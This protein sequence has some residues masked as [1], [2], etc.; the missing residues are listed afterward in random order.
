MLAVLVLICGEAE[1]VSPR[2]GGRMPEGFL[3]IVEESKA[4]YTTSR[5]WVSSR[6]SLPGGRPLRS[7]VFFPGGPDPVRLLPA[8]KGKIAIPVIAGLYSDFEGIPESADALQRRLFDGAAFPGTFSEYYDEVSFGL[9]DVTGTVYEWVG[10]SQSELYYTGYPTQGLTPGV[11]HTDEMI[12]ETVALLD[13]GVD[14]GLYD[15]DGPDGIPNSGDDD[16]YVDLLVIVHPTKGGECGGYDHMWSHSWQ[17]SGWNEE[18]QPLVTG[19]LSASGG[20]IL[21]DDYF[22][23]PT[24]SC[25]GGLI[26]IGVFCH[27]F[28]HSLGL[29]DLYD[30][31]GGGSGIGFWG[32]MGSGN[33]NTPQS[34]A[35]LSAWS[36]E[37]LGW[38][39]PVEI[40]WR[41]EERALES[42]GKSAEAFK[43]VLPAKRFRRMPNIFPVTGYAL[44]CGYTGAEADARGWNGGAG[45]G[46]GW[47][48]S[49][50]RHFHTDGIGDLT[51]EYNIGVDLEP[52]YDFAYL[53]L[54]TE[55]AEILLAE[56]SGTVDPVRETIV[57]SAFL[58]EGPSDFILK[59]LLTSDYNFSDEDN[60]YDSVEGWSLN[61]D[62][63]VLYGG[64]N[65][66]ASDFEEDAGGWLCDSEPSEY[67]LVENRRN[68]G[69]DRH[70]PGE[71]LLVW[72][73]ENSIAYSKLGNSGGYS[74]TQARGL[75][76]QEADGEFD[77]ISLLY[78]VDT[79]D[80]GD[81]FPGSS[82]NVLFDSTSLPSSRGNDHLATPVSIRGIS[83][84]QAFFKAGMPAP[85]ISSLDPETIDKAD[86]GPLEL[87]IFGSGFLY[88]TTCVLLQEGNVVFPLSVE[89]NGENSITAVF[90]R[91]GLYRGEWDIQITS[92]DGQTADLAGGLAV[93][94]IFSDIL[95]EARRSSIYLSWSIDRVDDLIGCI[96]YRMN[97]GTAFEHVGPDTLRSVSGLFEY[98]DSEVIPGTDYSYKITAF[99]P[100]SSE[101]L[102]LNGPWSIDY[103]PFSLDRA[104]PNPFGES[105]TVDFFIDRPILL[106]VMIFDVSGRLVQMMKKESYERGEHS[107]VWKPGARVASGVYFLILSNSNKQKQVKIVYLRR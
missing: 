68:Y 80:S 44:I 96:L 11:S 90:G 26:E 29:P 105:V 41:E 39:E 107:I 42:I 82:G 99:Y 89:W 21:I 31:N 59:F 5:R 20:Y 92:K 81:P 38:I 70:L 102:L 3:R 49:M 8:V 53:Y 10:L 16:G 27:E 24:V 1:A 77:L 30:Y 103:E 35:H 23:A 25:E 69:F 18:G 71:G 45:Y 15:N 58:P 74:N 33:W 104:Y 100:G 51:F 93:E 75:V 13:G 106:E 101:D 19:D 86:P 6:R 9:L 37:Q 52:D 7:S 63:V 66:Y 46:N 4:A 95:V 17:Y 12:S 97:E 32:L 48:E 54:L 2:D 28:G 84:S 60:R 40:G 67:F 98:S 22:I 64:G 61:I 55:E 88:G 34:P 50:I 47:K 62:N 56:Y 57:I 65:D 91:D 94:S 43:L 14:F 85:V 73:A 76:L 87:K 79:G 36:R 72:H 78:P 83:G